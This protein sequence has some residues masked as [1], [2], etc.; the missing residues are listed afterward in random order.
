MHINKKTKI[1][2]T[3]GPSSESKEKI[4]QAIE[5]GLNIFRF[6]LKHNTHEW[7][8][9]K[10]NRVREVAKEMGENIQIIADLRGPEIR[11]GNVSK[12]I[13]FN[14][15]TKIEIVKELNG[16]NQI[17]IPKSFFDSL[18]EGNTILIGD[19][20]IELKVKSVSSES[21]ICNILNH[22]KLRS[23]LTA[24]F[25]DIKSDNPAL[26]KKDIKDVS[27]AAKNN[28]DYLA[29]SF[30]RHTKDLQD[31]KSEVAKY[32][33]FNPRIITK[34]ETLEGTN[35]IES[36]IQETDVL[37]VARGDLAIEVGFEKVPYYQKQFIKLCKKHNKTSIVA[38][39]MMESMHE[40]P[41]P[42]RAEINDVATAVYDGA[43]CVML[44]GEFAMGKYP[45]QTVAMMS[46]ILSFT[47]S[48]I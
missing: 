40:N 14:S 34:L 23:S 30:V 9:E 39:Q 2:G 42:T 7:H 22:G 37:M 16:D 17:E 44:S 26:T 35:N 10:I 31:L 1:I 43:D 5:A 27:L 48:K 24:F 33:N 25:P 19:D 36:I 12:N 6:N 3:I 13:N 8:T 38:T 18:K 47:E 21:I 41:L 4:K 45:V 32:K 11:I 46:S 28:A 29:M 15:L 20:R